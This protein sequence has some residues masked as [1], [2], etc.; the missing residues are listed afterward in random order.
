MNDL[1]STMKNLKKEKG[2][3]KGSKGPGQSLTRETSQAL[4]SVSK[5]YD[6][7]DE[8]DNRSV[9]SEGS[10][11]AKP[12]KKIGFLQSLVVNTSL[13][14][15]DLDGSRR[16]VDLGKR[17]L[18]YSELQREIARINAKS[19][20]MYVIQNSK[21]EKI[22]PTNF[23]PSDKLFVRKLLTKPPPLGITKGMSNYWDTEEY[24]DAVH[25]VQEKEKNKSA[26]SLY[27]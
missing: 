18:T 12:T 9:N 24:H 15:I 4:V 3:K 10:F 21:G 26:V 13:E 7:N 1:K 17:V 16:I 11:D 23:A 25:Q 2:R 6:N 8:D 27:F 14:F 19:F 20:D 5:S 22:F